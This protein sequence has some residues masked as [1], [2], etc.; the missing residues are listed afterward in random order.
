LIDKKNSKYKLIILG[1]ELNNSEETKE[2]EEYESASQKSSDT[3]GKRARSRKPEKPNHMSFKFDPHDFE[4]L[5]DEDEDDDEDLHE[6][7][8]LFDEEAKEGHLKKTVD[9]ICENYLNSKRSVNNIETKLYRKSNTNPNRNN[10]SSFRIKKENFNDNNNN[11]NNNDD[12]SFDSN[13]NKQSS[14]NLSLSISSSGSDDIGDE[15][16]YF[17]YLN[18]SNVNDDDDE[19]LG[20]V[21]Y[22]RANVTKKPISNS[23]HS[24]KERERRDNLKK[25]FTRLKLAMF[26]LTYDLETPYYEDA[27]IKLLK[28]ELNNSNSNPRMKSKQRTLLEVNIF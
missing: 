21:S 1:K 17:D 24:I 18:N 13:D 19:N 8:A 25:L 6:Y 27:S 5:N 22:P 11:N 28:E 14:N 23:L 4:E 3:V 16:N 12:D 10:T 2:D 15:E 26:N 7:G 20:S 9:D